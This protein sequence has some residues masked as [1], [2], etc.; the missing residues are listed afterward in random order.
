M[1][2]GADNVRQQATNRRK[3][4]FDRWI[5][6]IRWQRGEHGAVLLQGSMQLR[7]ECEVVQVPQSVWQGCMIERLWNMYR[8]TGAIST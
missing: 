7:L 3:G 6:V 4:L 8:I 5:L 1:Q 2:K